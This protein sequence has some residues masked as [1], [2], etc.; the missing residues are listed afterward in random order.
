M[1]KKIFIFSLI[2]YL[3]CMALAGC[4]TNTE[5]QPPGTIPPATDETDISTPDTTVPDSATVPDDTTSPGD[6]TVP[7][8]AT[9]APDKD[10]S[11]SSTPSAEEPDASAEPEPETSPELETGLRDNT[12]RCLV[13]TASGS[14]ETH[15]EYAAIDYSNASEGYFM[16]CYTGTCAKVKMQVKGSNGVTYTYNL[17]NS[18]YVAFPLSSGSGSY[19]I[20]ILENVFDSNYAIC[21]AET[22]N[23]TLSSEF[24]PYLYPNQYCAF[25]SSSRAVSLAKELAEPANTDLDVI[26]NIY[27]YVIESI[28]YDYDKAATVPSGYI[29]DVDAVLSSGKGICLDYAAVM[30]SML[31]SQRIPTRLEVGYA[32]DAYHAWISAYIS[33][34]G[35]VNGIVRFDGNEWELMDPTFASMVEESE[36]KDFIS[37]GSNYVVKYLY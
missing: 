12:P 5:L 26:T 29:P 34:V 11:A 1:K 36:L 10:P 23:V 7:D 27:N 31:R 15:N 20:T 4:G 30:T 19:E 17:N 24:K 14:A 28:S 35:W 2:S 9:P 8:D 37:N 18:E 33:D 21:L 32:G 22:I 6:T 13:P 16:A 25:S 3:L